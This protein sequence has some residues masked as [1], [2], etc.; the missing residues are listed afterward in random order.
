MNSVSSEQRIQRAAT[1][2]RARPAAEVVGIAVAPLRC[3][4]SGEEGEIGRVDHDA[5]VSHRRALGVIETS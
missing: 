5:L 3:V 4:L 1:E 2:Q